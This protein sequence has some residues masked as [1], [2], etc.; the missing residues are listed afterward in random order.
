M[1]GSSQPRKNPYVAQGLIPG[2]TL[3]ITV[4]T[5]GGEEQLVTRVEDVD[6]ERIEV[7]VPMRRLALE[8]LPRGCLLR[9]AYTH[10]QIRRTFATEALDTSG[11]GAFQG[12]RAPALIESNERRDV[13]RLNTAIRPESLYRLVID[14][15]SDEPAVLEGVIIDLGEGGLCI[16]TANPLRVGER[17]GIHAA[18]GEEGEFRA[19][20]KVTELAGPAGGGRNYRVHCTFTTIGQADADRIARHLMRRQLELARRGQL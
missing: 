14:A 12:L 4:P 9:A 7:L 11:G 17:L 2:T 15:A 16:S 10:R 19:R 20:M 1:G 18:L 6:E 13:F 3:E 5:P 8:P